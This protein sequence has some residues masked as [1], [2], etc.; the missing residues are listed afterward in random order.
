MLK[1]RVFIADLSGQTEKIRAIIAGISS[2][3]E[4]TSTETA[5]DA[6]QQLN[7]QCSNLDL[8]LLGNGKPNEND[9]LG[10]ARQASELEDFMGLIVATSHVHRDAMLRSGCDIAIDKLG[11]EPQITLLVQA[12]ARALLHCGTDRCLLQTRVRARKLQERILGPELL[13]LIAIEA[14][15]EAT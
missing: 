7:V 3:I 12:Y 10:V 11:F 1:L 15:Q 6:L 9:L 5:E 8:L 13:D 4:M 2:D 14:S